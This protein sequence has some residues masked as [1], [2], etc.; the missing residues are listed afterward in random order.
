[1]GRAW[2]THWSD[3]KFIYNF[4]GKRSLGRR[5]H[6]WEDNITMELREIGYEGVDWMQLS[7]HRDQ[8]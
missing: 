3:E 6:R 5:R 4:E 8:W 2:S 1:M 7:Q